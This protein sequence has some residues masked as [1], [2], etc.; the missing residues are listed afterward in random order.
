MGLGDWLESLFGPHEVA[1]TK[2]EASADVSLQRNPVTCC[3]RSDFIIYAQV[4]EFQSDGRDVHDRPRGG[5][6]SCTHC[7]EVWGVNENGLYRPNPDA[8]PPPLALAALKHAQQRNGGTPP[9][10]MPT[11]RSMAAEFRTP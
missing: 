9:P 10:T 6:V 7:G 3:G 2:R 8:L 5:I 4:R 11:R 1:P